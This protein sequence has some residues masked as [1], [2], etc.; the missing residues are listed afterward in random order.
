MSTRRWLRIAA[1]AAAALL[2]LGIIAT[3]VAAS[4]DEVIDTSG[5]PEHTV[6]TSRIEVPVGDPPPVGVDENGVDLSASSS[7]ILPEDVEDDR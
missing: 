5:Q 1:G 3:R 4:E 7:P 2:A 6:P